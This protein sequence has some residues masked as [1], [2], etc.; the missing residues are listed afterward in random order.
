MQ[1]KPPNVGAATK[2]RM[3]VQRFAAAP[4]TNFITPP[5]SLPPPTNDVTPPAQEVPAAVQQDE[6]GATFEFEESKQ[7]DQSLNETVNT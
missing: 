5:S 4:V 2:R 6:S 3:P 1:K 7:M